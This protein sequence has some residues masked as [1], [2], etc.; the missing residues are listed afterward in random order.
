MKIDKKEI[1]KALLEALEASVI[2]ME[3]LKDKVRKFDET[4]DLIVNLKNLNLNDPKNRIDEEFVLPNNILYDDKIPV[5]FIAGGDIQVNAK[6][7]G[8][9]VVDSEALEQLDKEQKKDKKKFVKKYKYFIAEQKLMRDVARYLARFLGPL[10]KMPK[11]IPKGY[12]IIRD[13]DDIKDVIERHRRIVRI[14]MR[15]QPLIQIPVGKKSMDK[16]KIHENIMTV[17][18][19]IVE[20][21]PNKMNNIRSIYLKTTMGKPIKVSE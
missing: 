18:N 20:E 14:R 8:Y 10:G 15:K 2:K 6:K 9:D 1:E 5:C 21:M 17:V 11:P 19:H 13:T 3:G 16:N 7:L 4:I 12:G